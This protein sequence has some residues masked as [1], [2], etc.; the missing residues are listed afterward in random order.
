MSAKM[1]FDVRSEVVD[2]TDLPH[3]RTSGHAAVGH[4][5]VPEGGESGGHRARQEHGRLRVDHLGIGVGAMP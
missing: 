3:C 1:P 4:A 5:D 2:A